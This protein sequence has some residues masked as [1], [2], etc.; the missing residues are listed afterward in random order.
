MPRKHRPWRLVV[1]FSDEPIDLDDWAKRYVALVH[2]TAA[3]RGHSPGSVPADDVR[4]A[5]DLDLESE[6]GREE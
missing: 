1:Q 4:G 3:K 5:N 6:A 2:E